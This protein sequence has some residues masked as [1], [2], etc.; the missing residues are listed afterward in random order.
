MSESP[1]TIL[2]HA[3]LG[4]KLD[5]LFVFDVHMHL[6]DWFQFYMPVRDAAGA[7]KIMD[8]IGISAGVASARSAA[9][10]SDLR[11]GNDLV[12]DAV[13]KF[14]GR[15]YG[16]IVADPNDPEGMAA[17]IERCAQEGVR[18]IK[19]HH[20][21]GHAYDAPEYA[22]AFEIADS[23]AWPVLAYAGPVAVLDTLAERYKNIRWI[24]AHAASADAG[25]FAEL[26]R[27]RENVFFDTCG[28]ACE[29]GAV[30]DLVRAVGVERVLFGSDAVLLSA[31]QQ[32]G[33]ILFAR[34]TDEEKAHI[35]GLNAARVF[36]I[37][38]P[39]ENPPTP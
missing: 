19:V 7:V 11:A 15:L 25:P 32:I 2:D 36:D 35:L 37:P 34:L 1:R 31:S 30:E 18:A 33:R 29:Y 39:A 22:A 23:R 21:H 24:I 4:L 12:V 9:A 6:G 17:E 8:R 38:L 10:G 3:R 5:G 13:R 27:R 20:G 26:A 28:S 16:Y 14:P